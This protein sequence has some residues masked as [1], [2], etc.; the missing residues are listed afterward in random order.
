LVIGVGKDE[1][2][3][4]SDATPI[5]EYTNEV[6]YVNDYEIAVIK[7][8]KLDIKT[9]EDVHT[10]PYIQKLELKLDAIEKGGYEHFMLKEIFEQP[11]SIMDS[12]RGRLN[13]RSES[14]DDGR[15]PGVCQ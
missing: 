7:D 15:Y 3:L 2:F 11:R 6:I 13:C 9:K 14:P 12:M 4:A 5:V 10:N 8:G 1:F